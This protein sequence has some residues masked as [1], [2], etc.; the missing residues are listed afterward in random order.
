MPFLYCELAVNTYGEDTEEWARYQIGKMNQQLGNR[1]SPDEWQRLQVEA[2]HPII[3][4]LVR[5]ELIQE[6]L[7]SG[8]GIRSTTEY[9]DFLI[10]FPDTL[11]SDL[12]RIQYQQLNERGNP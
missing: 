7:P 3:H 8:S 9:Q 4:G 5:Y 1:G 11:F 10:D 12:A 6:P 2:D